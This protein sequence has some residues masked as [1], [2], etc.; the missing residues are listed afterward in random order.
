MLFLL[1]GNIKI[2]KEHYSSFYIYAACTSPE[3]RGMGLMASL[4]CRVAE[5]AV[6]DSKDYICLVPANAVLFEYYARF[7]FE[8]SFKKKEISVS[9]RQLCMIAAENAENY[10]PDI[11]EITELRNKVFSNGDYYVWDEKN[12]EYSIYENKSIGGKTIY[13]GK[14][15]KLAGY[16]MFIETV[17]KVIIKELCVLNGFLD[18]L[19]RLLVSSVKAENFMLNLPVGFPLTSDNFVIKEN[20]MAKPIST[21]GKIALP[22]VCNAYIGLTLE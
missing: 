13:L 8:T 5:I 6:A 9:R 4:I 7:G 14:N 19:I 21:G 10:Y 17:E 3:Y 18:S 20:G 1:D 16:A 2:A 15:G 22:A 11:Q 12:I